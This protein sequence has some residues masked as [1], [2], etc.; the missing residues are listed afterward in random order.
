MIPA[1]DPHR[2]AA[3]LAA[4]DEIV[5]LDA[6]ERH[7]RLDAIGSEDPEML[8]ALEQLLAADLEAD[9]RL[10]R[11]DGALG[12]GGSHSGES[13]SHADPLHLVGRTVSHFR[14]LAPL[15]QGGMGVLYRAEDMRLERAVALKLPLAT[16]HLDRSVKE[17]FLHEARLAGALDHPNLCSIY[18]AGETDDGHLFYA[19]PLYPGETLRARLSREGALPVAEALRIAKQI[20]HGLGAAHQ[21]GIVHRDLKPANVMVLP[22]GAV[23]ILDFG[24]ARANDLSLTTSR[25]ALG[26]VAYMAPEQVQGRSL[27]GRADL[28]ALGVLLYEMLTGSRPFPGDEAVAI[29]H[30]ILHTEPLPASALRRDIPADLDDV[31]RTL[32]S[33]VP[34]ERYA[35]AEDVSTAVALIQLGAPSASRVSSPE[36]AARTPRPW[37]RPIAVAVA[38]VAVIALGAWLISRGTAS[39][40]AARSVAVVPFRDSSDA[41]DGGYIAVG[42]SDAIATELSRLRGVIVPGYLSTS[43]YRA[44]SRTEREIANA[45]EVSAVVTGTLRRSG[46]RAQVMIRLFD[47]TSNRALAA[48]RYDRPLTELLDVQRAATR[49]IVATLGIAVTPAERVVL[50]RAPTTNPRAYDW[51]LRGRDI[52]L[53]ALSRKFMATIPADGLRLA[54]SFYSRARD[55]DPSFAIARA[56]LATTLMR[57]A[58][59]Y[60]STEARREHARLEAETALRLQ[61]G[62]AE[63]HAALASYW[64]YRGRDPAKAIVE[65]ELALAGAPNSGELHVNLGNCYVAVGRW[66]DAVA[67][68]ERAMRVDARNPDAPTYAALTL[69]RLRRDEQAMRAFDRAIELAPDNHMVRVIKGHTYLR[70]RGTPDSLAAVL[71]TVPPNWDPDGMT[72]WARYTVLRVQR[73]HAEARS[74]LD[75]SGSALSRDGLVYQPTLLMRAQTYEALGETAKARAYYEAA[76]SMLADSVKAHPNDASI[77]VTL[78]LA[79]ASLGRK[80]D[81]IR[82]ARR[83]M[84]L[85]PLSSNSPGATALMGGAVEVFGRAGE[86]DAAFELL[87][88]L[89]AMPAG[90]EVTVPFLRVWPG[91]DPLREDPRFDRLLARFGSG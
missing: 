85:V 81:A 9:T 46:D 84:E 28:F 8:R 90:R 86:I 62:L 64:G 42:L 59:T 26:T 70:W 10:A 1:I 60:D 63:A 7:A 11:I 19:M 44:T 78:G 36:R 51:Y 87:E 18:E 76:R 55:L 37:T 39:P 74:M 72:T 47:T 77:R 80:Q 69:L 82:E 15:A 29:M 67:A 6:D 17:R 48:Q 73:R 41:A 83:A 66:E 2:W 25:A 33:K 49:E 27:D 50:D 40:H 88:L 61:P 57:G 21:A 5:E 3:V 54:Q 68:F 43:T 20:A 91:F 65:A 79:E 56:R 16:A 35:S 38:V 4:F 13:A 53:Q 89:L 12:T 71:R 34:S 24:L 22:D 23:K 75:A 32:L 14:V 45:L 52:E 58:M 31:V 30:A